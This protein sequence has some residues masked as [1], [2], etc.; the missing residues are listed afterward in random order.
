MSVTDMFGRLLTCTNRGQVDE[1]SLAVVA[2][3]VGNRR[4]IDDTLSEII[5]NIYVGH[6]RTNVNVSGIWVL[7]S[8]TD[9][10]VL[11]VAWP[12]RTAVNQSAAAQAVMIGTGF[13]QT[14]RVSSAFRSRTAIHP[15]FAY[16]NRSCLRARR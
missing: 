7:E 5:L 8:R 2:G 3:T 12:H 14:D 9:S 6:A 13:K 10:I 16:K 11:T 4:A 15:R 1:K